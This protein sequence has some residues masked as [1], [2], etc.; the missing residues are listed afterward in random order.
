MNYVK[1][2]YINFAICEYYNDQSFSMVCQLIFQTIMNQDLTDVAD[3]RNLHKLIFNF[4]E[5]FFKN[6][7]ELIFLKFNFSILIDFI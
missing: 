4:V 5:D 1:G 2:K 7:L 6:H 3:Y